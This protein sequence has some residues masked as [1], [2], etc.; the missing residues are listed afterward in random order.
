MDGAGLQIA[1]VDED[2]KFAEDG[3]LDVGILPAL[4]KIGRASCRERV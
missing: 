1:D 3:N 4:L 2:S